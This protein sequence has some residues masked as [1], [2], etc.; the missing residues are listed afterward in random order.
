MSKLADLWLKFSS[1]YTVRIKKKVIHIQWPIVLKSTDLKIYMWHI[2][3]MPDPLFARFDNWIKASLPNS[4]IVWLLNLSH[5]MPG[6]H[7]LS[8]KLE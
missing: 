6:D 3:T 5:I 1:R 2:M 4:V 7:F 8:G